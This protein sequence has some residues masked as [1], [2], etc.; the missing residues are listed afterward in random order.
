LALVALAAHL[1]Q[2]APTLYSAQS[3]LLAVA[4]AVAIAQTSTEQ[5]LQAAPAVVAPITQVARVTPPQQAQAKVIMVVALLAP[6]WVE[7]AAA[8]G[9]VLLALLVV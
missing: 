8:A 3:L 4:E 6:D 1:E 7:A 5:V 9:Q 2:V